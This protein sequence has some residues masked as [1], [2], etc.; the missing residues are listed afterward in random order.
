MKYEGFVFYNKR[1]LRKAKKRIVRDLLALKYFEP[2]N[3]KRFPTLSEAMA[4]LIE[5]EMKYL[6]E[7]IDVLNSLEYE[8]EWLR[9]CVVALFYCVNVEAWGVCVLS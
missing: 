4:D 7:Q 8:I 9:V 1:T 5:L 2:I 3:N 6:F